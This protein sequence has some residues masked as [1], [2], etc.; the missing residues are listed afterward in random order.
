[1]IIDHIASNYG[2][3]CLELFDSFIRGG[4]RQERYYAKDGIH[5]SFSGVKRLLGE[6]NK[7]IE[8]V[9]DFNMCTYHKKS[10][11]NQHTQR[12]AQP[13]TNKSWSL[14]HTRR[15][16]MH[17]RGPTV[18]AGPNGNVNTNTVPPSTH[19]RPPMNNKRTSTN[20][21]RPAINVRRPF[22]IP[23]ANDGPCTHCRIPNHTVQECRY[24]Q[25]FN[26]RCYSCFEFGHREIDCMNN[27]P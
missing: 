15:P 19:T 7:E 17:N 12:Y 3:K 11:S 18:H 27:M 9:S 13:N 24:N 21:R 23:N 16:P 25:T 1:M 22:S 6:I 20:S 4:Y 14:T 8:I 26:G 5:L 2:V 10:K